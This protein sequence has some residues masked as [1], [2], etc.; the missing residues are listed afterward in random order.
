M[1]FDILAMSG[2]GLY[3][4]SS[5]ALTFFVFLFLFLKTR[6]TLKKLETEFKDE[7]N[8]LSERQ[9]EAL[10]EKKVAQEISKSK[11]TR[12]YYAI[13]MITEHLF[14]ELSTT[15]CGQL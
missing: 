10:K 14:T 11:N 2:Y 15:N 5:F 4:A 6:K 9:L 12:E 13:P 1:N 8:K 3:V 7:A